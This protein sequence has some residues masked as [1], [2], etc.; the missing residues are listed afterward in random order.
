MLI[1]NT[2]VTPTDLVRQLVNASVCAGRILQS[3]Q[4]GF[5]HYCYRQ[6][7]YPTNDTIPLVENFQFA[8]A[9]MRERTAESFAEA[10]TLIDKL[11]HFQDLS[12]NFPVYLHEYPECKDRWLVASILPVFVW[13][14]RHFPAVLAGALRDRFQQSVQKAL[15]Y[16]LTLRADKLPV[17]VGVKI[18]CSAH[19][20]G[21]VWQRSDLVQLAD[22]WLSE[23]LVQAED[24]NY[25]G[26]YVPQTLAET[27]ASLDL[28]Y[29]DLSSS[30]WKAVWQQAFRFWHPTL[31]SYVG[32]GFRDYQYSEQ[33]EVTLLDL[34]VGFHVGHYAYRALVTGPHLLA[35]S[36]LHPADSAIPPE[37]LPSH[38][39]G[40]VEGRRWDL[41][42]EQTW[43][44]S[45][46]EKQH[47]DPSRDNAYSALRLLWGGLIAA[48]T[49]VCQGGNSER[50]EYQLHP[51]GADLLITLPEEVPNEVRQRNR[52]VSFYLDVLQGATITVSDQA[53]AT[54]FQCGELLSIESGGMKLQLT[55]TIESGRGQ[56]FGH[57]AKGNRP[58]QK[59]VTGEG[60]F[61]NYD[62]H[63]FLRTIHRDSQCKIRAAL[64]FEP[65]GEA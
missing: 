54:T 29:S 16:C 5:V 19:A 6:L 61:K 26:W 7:D 40:T 53:M 21:K 48:H 36:I 23:L 51:D 3:S 20:L 8:L 35:A 9:L 15:D 55:L 46:L 22:A 62:W 57:I 49:C 25:S 28:V 24:P 50:V 2:P 1:G 64:R 47:A 60:R 13:I 39:S 59:H 11:L 41:L 38:L 42:K 34:Y 33:P 18:A 63:I 43:T 17:H 14:I 10:K 65:R 32:P 12:G 58:S 52:E 30:P 27:L 4:T 31:L 45:V 37:A 56:F 44:F